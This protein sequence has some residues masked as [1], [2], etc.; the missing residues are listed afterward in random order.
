MTVQLTLQDLES[1]ASSMQAQG[2]SLALDWT[3]KVSSRSI[4]PLTPEIPFDS[5][6]YLSYSSFDVC[7]ENLVS[8]Q[9]VIP[10]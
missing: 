9:L 10:N 7:S 4:N 5:P 1:T 3:V 6:Y 8:D 2:I